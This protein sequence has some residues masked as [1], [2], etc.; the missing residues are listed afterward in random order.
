TSGPRYISNTQQNTKGL[1]TFTPPHQAVAA[2]AV[3]GVRSIVSD[4]HDDHV[5]VPGEADRHGGGV[6]GV[7]RDVGQSLLDD[8][9][10]GG[11]HLGRPPL[12]RLSQPQVPGGAAP[13]RETLDEPDELLQPRNGGG[14]R[15][16][17]V[18]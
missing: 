17:G 14:G 6:R 3:A 8:P 16:V 2:A 11:G 18:A 10:D 7:T 1:N 13:L 5:P 9:M 15:S 4:L 12:P